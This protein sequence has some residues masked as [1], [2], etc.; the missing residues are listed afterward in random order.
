MVFFG[1]AVASANAACPMGTETQTIE[2][3]TDTECMGISAVTSQ[4]QPVNPL[5]NIKA[6]TAQSTMTMSE[7]CSQDC[8]CP[9]GDLVSAILF[10][11]PDNDWEIASLQKKSKSAFLPIRQFPNTLYRPPISL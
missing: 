10:T 3:N 6:C 2:W 4:K 7:Y 1:Q 11:N 9:S 5:S 8:N